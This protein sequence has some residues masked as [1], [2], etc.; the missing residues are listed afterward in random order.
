[1]GKYVLTG[2]QNFLLLEKI[3]QSL[4]G[5]VCL[6]RLLPF[7]Q[8]ELV[9]HPFAKKN[10]D[11][12]LF[13]GKYPPLLDREIPPEDFYPSY[14]E[15]YLERDVRNIKNLGK[16]SL[17]RKF[18]KLCAG[19][20]GQLV[21]FE[22]LGNET[23]VDAK[24]IKSWLS[25]LEASYI[26]FFLPP[27]HK[28]F[29][30]RIVKRPKLYF[31]D[32]GLVCSLL[33]LRQANHLSQFYLRGNLFENSIISEIMKLHFHK[34][35]KPNIYFWRDSTGNEVDLIIDEGISYKAIEIKSGATLNESFFKNLK[36]FHKYS[37]I[38]KDHC[39]LIYNGVHEHVYKGY[40][41]LSW[42]SLEKI[43]PQLKTP[44]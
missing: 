27:F 36:V 14:V 18:L 13:T 38:E 33:G 41:V 10:L 42:R 23:G 4:A 2:S 44:Q 1:M 31:C 11:E 12:I 43:S 5:R 8:I 28:N 34:G 40:N 22:S 6:P 16:L 29:N 7:D 21:N 19:R 24:I 3:T 25:I 30:K 20:V 35:Q 26:I 17:F 9:D 37:N 39:Y 15:T 32:T